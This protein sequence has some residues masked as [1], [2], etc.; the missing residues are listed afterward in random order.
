MKYSKV[1]KSCIFEQKKLRHSFPFQPS[2]Y[3][4]DY[5]LLPPSLCLSATA[6]RSTIPRSKG[7][8]GREPLLPDNIYYQNTGIRNR[9]G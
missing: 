1:I 7:D 3:S 2:E 8:S 5:L 6:R 9:T 4:H